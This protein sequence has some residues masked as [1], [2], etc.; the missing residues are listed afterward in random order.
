[1]ALR[2]VRRVEP[3]EGPAGDEDD[4]LLV[5]V[6]QGMREPGRRFLFMCLGGEKI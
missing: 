4:A 5:F 3:Q 6:R 2:E 1:M